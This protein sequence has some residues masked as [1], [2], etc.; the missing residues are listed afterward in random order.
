MREASSLE[1]SDDGASDWTADAGTSSLA[2]G[3]GESDEAASDA[4]PGDSTAVALATSDDAAADE[5]AASAVDDDPPGRETAKTGSEGVTFPL[6]SLG[7]AI[8]SAHTPCHS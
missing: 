1:T 8:R 2:E 5:L 6:S 3:L 4:G 7:A